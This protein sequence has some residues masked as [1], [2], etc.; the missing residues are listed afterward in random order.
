MISYINEFA[1]SLDDLLMSDIFI[2]IHNQVKVIHQEYREVRLFV[3]AMHLASS[4]DRIISNE[5]CIDLT[6]YQY[7]SDEFK[8][9]FTSYKEKSIPKIVQMENLTTH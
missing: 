4:V 3:H 8:Q 2:D 1:R 5:Y 9:V 7:L 6:K